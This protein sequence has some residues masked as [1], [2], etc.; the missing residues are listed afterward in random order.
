MRLPRMTTRRW[1]VAVAIIAL[2]LF[3][4]LR[5]YRQVIPRGVDLYPFWFASDA[6][7]RLVS[8]DGQRTVH[9]VFNDAGAVHSGFHW[10]WLI[11]DD[12]VL[13]RSVV[14]EGY[15]LPS[16]REGEV[17]FPLRWV[18]DRT[19]V[20]GFVAGRH[21]ATPVERVVRLR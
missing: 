4:C 10:T 6:G 1:M 13:G 2:V 19:F 8:P 3:S 21:D 18:D 12:L 5:T 7:P 20:A 15:S 16:V 9:V 14:A 11:V 17:S